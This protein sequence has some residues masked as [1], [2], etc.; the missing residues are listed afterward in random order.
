MDT[1][2]F[3]DTFSSGYGKDSLVSPDTAQLDGS[4]CPII[5]L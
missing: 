5:F 4:Q 1:F 2:F 3:L